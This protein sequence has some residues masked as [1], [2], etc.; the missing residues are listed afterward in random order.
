MAPQGPQHASPDQ[1]FQL[2]HFAGPVV[3]KQGG[4]R[5]GAESQATKVQAHAVLLQEKAAEQQDVPPTL[6]QGGHRQGVDAE[7]MVNVCPQ[8]TCA[9][10]GGQVT[11][12]RDN[13]AHVSPML[14][15]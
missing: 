8:T 4:Q 3:G 7:P 15:V 14:A 2:T 9:H 10:L 6:P 12:R 13:Q 1:V 5:I 11:V